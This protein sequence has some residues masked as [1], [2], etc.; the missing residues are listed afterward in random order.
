M[1]LAKISFV[2]VLCND[3]LLAFVP[4]SV[5]CSLYAHNLAIWSSF[6]TVSAVVEATQGA[7]IQLEC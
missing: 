4:S 6:P 5:C 7:L 3:D 1:C 2:P